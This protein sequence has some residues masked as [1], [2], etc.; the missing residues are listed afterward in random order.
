MTDAE[1]WSLIDMSRAR[2][3]GSRKRQEQ[4]LRRL[5]RGLSADDL[6]EFSVRYDNLIRKAY[7]WDLWAAAFIIQRGCSDDGFWDFRGWLVSRGKKVYDAAVRDP[8]SLRRVVRGRPRDSLN[9][10]D[11]SSFVWEE[12]TGLPSCKCPGLGSN[13]GEEPAGEDWD[14]W[15]LPQR[16]P[17]LWKRFGWKLQKKK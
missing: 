3:R 4:I 15:D 1:F 10:L 5:Q 12:K 13:L 7:H 11:Y 2:S 8:E 6:A 14:E 16:L 17:K 9:F